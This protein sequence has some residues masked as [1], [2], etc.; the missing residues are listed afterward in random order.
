[1]WVRAW[2]PSSNHTR[3]VLLSEVPLD[4]SDRPLVVFPLNPRTMKLISSLV[5]LLVAPALV[6]SQEV[7]R[8]SF[9][10]HTYIVELAPS[11]ITWTAAEASAVG[12]GGHLASITSSAEEQFVYSLASSSPLLWPREGGNPNGPGIG[13]WLG[14]YKTMTGWGWSDGSIFGYSNWAA[15]EPNNY[16]GNENHIMFLSYVGQPTSDAWNDYPDDV[17]GDGIHLGPNPHGYVIE[18]VPET[19]PTSLLL[20]G[21]A[22]FVISRR[23]VSAR[24]LARSY[25]PIDLSCLNSATR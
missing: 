15:G 8:G 9:N 4:T 24:I 13:P 10:N 12:M 7:T 1:M 23:S 18:M 3:C 16:G 19:S 6:F 11:G 14:G 21:L 20:L 17:T 22:A 2:L 5:G 25:G